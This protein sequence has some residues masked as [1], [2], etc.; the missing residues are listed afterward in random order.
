[1][2]DEAGASL[3]P[4]LITDYAQ[5]R[6]FWT[7]PGALHGNAQTF[8]WIDCWRRHV[9][10][11][12]LVAG[13]F[14]NDT[15]IMMLP[16]EAVSQNGARVLRYPGGSHA[17]CN[18]P[19][20][21]GSVDHASVSQLVSAIRT[22]R[23]DIDML[24]LTRQLP[25]LSGE[26]NPLLQLKNIENPNPVLAASL[27]HGFDAVLGRSNTK[28][29]LKKH[30]QHGRRYEESGGWRIY[31]PQS[32]K[33][34]D[35][36]LDI[37]FA[38]KA[39]RFKQMGIRDPFAGTHI[40][41]FFKELYG[42]AAE[43]QH[44]VYQLQILEVGGKIRSLIGKTFSKDGPT[45]EFNAIADDELM[46]ASPGEFLFYE[47]IKKSCD[48]ELPVYSFGIGDEPYKREWC[49]IESRIFDAFVPLTTK[50][51]AFTALQSIRSQAIATVKGN[52]RLWQFAKALRSK[53]A[54]RFSF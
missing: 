50:G 52:P 5:L 45:V 18:F 42:D 37:F 29:K 7:K 24:S 2:T 1:M 46:T 51:K 41:A 21:D 49:D 30:R 27:G 35:E 6:D 44:A 38:L 23:P 54:K 25:S 4:R 39:H 32:R 53:L 10:P 17:N 33:E 12:S 34:A 28:R 22:A 14:T 16:L 19:W 36:I 3:T 47:D 15:P 48:A 40:Q 31:A 9:N 26:D 8:D 13:L 20:L 11:D 43:S